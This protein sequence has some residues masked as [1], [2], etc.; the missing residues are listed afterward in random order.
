MFYVTEPL[1]NPFLAHM[2]KRLLPTFS[3]VRYAARLAPHYYR[4]KKRKCQYYDRAGLLDKTQPSLHFTLEEMDR[5]N[6]LLLRM[7]IDP[8]QRFVCVSAR[9]AG[10]FAGDL[11]KDRSSGDDFRNTTID[12]FNIAVE[13]LSAMGYP[14]IRMGAGVDSPWDTD[15]PLAVD[16]AYSNRSDFGD[17]FLCAHCY[18]FLGDS[19]GLVNI[20]KVFRRPCIRVNW[21][22]LQLINTS[23]S[24]DLFLP[25]MIRKKEL[26][27]EL[28]FREILTS[29]VGTFTRNE[30]YVMAGL[31]VI[32]NSPEEIRDVAVEMAT[33]LEGTWGQKQDGELRQKKFWSLWNPSDANEPFNS[34]IGSAF[35]KTHSHLLE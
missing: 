20:P 32:H 9:Q 27:T 22:P 30:E 18:F 4:V 17:I 26:G 12:Q 11:G 14:V 35:L 24:N 28:T 2:W 25:A 10:Y 8:K 31:E 33:R 15:A 29:S 7:G 23:C 34:R 19:G 21:F 5:G 6:E 16:Y 1:A 3:S 13:E